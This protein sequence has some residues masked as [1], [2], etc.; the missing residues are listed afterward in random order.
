MNSA[1]K[2][3]EIDENDVPVPP[4]RKSVKSEDSNILNRIADAL[5]NSP[6]NQLVSSPPPPMHDEIDS[7]TATLGYQLRELPAQHRRNVMR[8]LLNLIVDAVNNYND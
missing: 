7:F 3:G 8:D 6:S 4:K 1:N 5:C 2:D